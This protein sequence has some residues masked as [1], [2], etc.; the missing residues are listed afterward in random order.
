MDRFKSLL[1]DLRYCLS[2]LYLY[3]FKGCLGL[4]NAM[5]ILPDMSKMTDKV[6]QSIE[7]LLNLGDLDNPWRALFAMPF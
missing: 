6:Q 7:K 2:L 5:H 1:S 4:S 3:L